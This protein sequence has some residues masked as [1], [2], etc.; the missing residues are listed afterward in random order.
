MLQLEVFNAKQGDSLLLHYG[1]GSSPGLML[2]D[3]GPS[4]VYNC[5]IRKRL[6]EL[7][8]SRGDEKPLP[9]DLVMVTH[10]D[11]DHIHGIVDLSN[12]LVQHD[13]DGTPAPFVVNGLWHNSFE[14]TMKGVAPLVAQQL[15]AGVA[16]A[17]AVAS[18]A[19]QALNLSSNAVQVASVGQGA[20]LR[21][22]ARRLGWPLNTG[23][24][25]GLVVEGGGP[26]RQ[27]PAWPNLTVIGPNAAEV[28][29]LRQ[30][31]E[32]TIQSAQ[33]KPAAEA[34]V[35]VAAFVDKSVTNLSS[36][37][38]LAKYAGKSMLL[39]GDARG[40]YLLDGLR[41]AGVLTG[42]SCHVDVLKLPHHGSDR[43]LAPE[44]F[45]QIKADHYVISA[46]GQYDNP[47][48]STLQMLLDARTDDDFALHITNDIPKVT[49]FLNGQISAGRHFRLNMRQ[50]GDCSVVIPLQ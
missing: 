36:I 7:K 38:V 14:A 25:D 12:D 41:S 26:A 22:N 9:I 19:G 29:A 20:T 18:V 4:G 34:S 28:A 24:T 8:D 13:T 37:A 42:A 16:P 15:N 11:D 3:G 50:P 17:Q 10:I 35:E 48:I 46:D 23:F 30:E 33:S 2:I 47:S 1:D 6:L 32:K 21:N 31:W 39:T 43:D 40:D 44:F 49:Q 27:D 45:Q 5:V